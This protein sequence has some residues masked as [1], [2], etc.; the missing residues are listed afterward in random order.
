MN[1]GAR[2]ETSDI[3]AFILKI[4]FLTKV[5]ITWLISAHTTASTSTWNLPKIHYDVS[6]SVYVCWHA[7]LSSKRQKQLMKRQD[8]AVTVEYVKP[9]TR[10][11]KEWND[12][13]FAH[14]KR[15]DLLEN[16]ERS[17]ISTIKNEFKIQWAH[18]SIYW[19]LTASSSS[20]LLPQD[21]TRRRW[22]VNF[23][24]IERLNGSKILFMHE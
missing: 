6:W 5:N 24:F 9:S 10:E 13:I 18:N 15:V 14:N 23:V 21:S 20:S 2:S 4:D 1:S 11:G 8:P 19:V 16:A 12:K 22:A 3:V 17:V 7:C